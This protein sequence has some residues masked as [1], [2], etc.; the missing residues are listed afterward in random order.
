MRR[1]HYLFMVIL[2]FVLVTTLSCGNKAS[3]ATHIIINKTMNQVNSQMER[4]QQMIHNIQDSVN[5]LNLE[6][7]RNIPQRHNRQNNQV[8]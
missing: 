6:K 5:R 2:S 1:V 4:N 8:W 3:R 7:N